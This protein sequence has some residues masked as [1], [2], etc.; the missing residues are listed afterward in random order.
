MK[1]MRMTIEHLDE[2]QSDIGYCT[3]RAAQK[4]DDLEAVGMEGH[5]T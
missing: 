3:A 2:G 4:H 1:R 5:C